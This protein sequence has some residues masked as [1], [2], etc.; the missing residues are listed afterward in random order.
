ML[1]AAHCRL[2]KSAPS[3][4]NVTFGTAIMRS[5]SPSSK[6]LLSDSKYFTVHFTCYLV[7]GTLSNN[8]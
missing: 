7:L 8:N 1:S 3:A 5:S 4:G 6:L 2:A